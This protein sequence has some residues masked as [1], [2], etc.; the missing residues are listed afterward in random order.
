M[1]RES[2]RVCVSL[3]FRFGS[4]AYPHAE[5]ILSSLFWVPFLCPALSLRAWI[6]NPTE[7]PVREDVIGGI[8][9]SRPNAFSKPHN[10][11]H[12][13]SVAL[14][15]DSLTTSTEDHSFL[16]PRDRRLAQRVL[17]CYFDNLNPHRPVFMRKEFMS[18]VDALYDSLDH[19]GGNGDGEEAKRRNETDMNMNVDGGGVGSGPSGTGTD[20]HGGIGGGLPGAGGGANK[21]KDLASDAGFLCSVYL[22]F[23][24]GTMAVRN[25][26]AHGSDSGDGMEENWPSHEYFYDLALLL[27]P[28]LAN[29]ISTLQALILLHWYLYCEVRKL[30]FIS[31]HFIS[32]SVLF[33][34]TLACTFMSQAGAAFSLASSN[35]GRIVIFSPGLGLWN[36]LY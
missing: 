28:D 23:A 26:R 25:R 24:L 3:A 14:H 20:G 17:D 7:P 5:H 4:P 1:R 18:Q 15:R 30:F 6:S 36:M 27:K 12:W 9:M 22:V 35:P 10:P 33:C 21:H 34:S 8:G 32:C 31:F 19:P 2:S 11:A 16:L 29:S 13:T